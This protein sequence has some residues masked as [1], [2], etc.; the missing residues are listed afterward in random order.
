[1][2]K[3][4]LILFLTEVEQNGIALLHAK[5]YHWFKSEFLPHLKL[6]DMLLPD[7][8]ELMA[9]C[10][11]LVGDIHDFNGAP[12]QA[13]DAYKK[14]L[15]YDDDV[16]GAYREIAYMYEQV[17]RYT[18]ALDYINK[19]LEKLPDDEELMDVKAS[20]QD[21]INYT[22][23]PFLTDQ[24]MVWKLSELLAEGNLIPVVQKVLEL[25]QPERNVLQCLAQAYGAEGKETLYWETWQQIMKASGNLE[26]GY[27]DWFYM[28]LS[29]FNSKKW[30]NFLK[31]IA[32]EVHVAEFVEFDSLYEHYEAQLSQAEMIGL[33]ADFQLYKLAKDHNSIQALA[34]KYP[35][36]EE[37]QG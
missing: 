29:I 31:T 4:Q 17:G 5:G 3:E 33:I 1:M 24:N 2:D 28:P 6:A 16:D 7:A 25:E 22:T 8:V 11:Y 36:W 27:S 20:I 26:L 15:E 30:W 32:K 18:E 9:D 13:V 19:A 34:Q 35:L 12:L 10:W 23:E 21:S 14:A 37:V